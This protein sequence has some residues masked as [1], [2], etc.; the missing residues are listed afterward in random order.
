MN[1]QPF[2]TAPKDGNAF[3][4]FY[5]DDS[6]D[7]EEAKC[8]SVAYVISWEDHHGDGGRNFW[9]TLL[10]EGDPLETSRMPTHWMP[11]PPPPTERTR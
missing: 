7:P 5:L 2:E 1:W 6:E 3:L 11:L 10:P 9:W 4:A 8:L